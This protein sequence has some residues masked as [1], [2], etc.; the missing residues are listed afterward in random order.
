MRFIDKSCYLENERILVIGDLHLGYEQGLLEKGIS[1]PPTGFKE[2]MND[3]GKI[4]NNIGEIE[5]IVILGDLKHDFAGME[6]REA[7]NVLRVLE[8][9]KGK[10]KKI[11]VIKGNHDNYVIGALKKEGIE[12]VK[13]YEKGDILFMHGDKKVKIREGIKRIFLGHMHPAIS[14]KKNVKE[15]RYKCFLV[16]K[17]KNKEIIIL[18]S[19]F[20]LF[21][22]ADI[23]EDKGE[24]LAYDF[25]LNEFD[26]YIV[27]GK[28]LEVLHFGKLKDVGKLV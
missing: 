8:F 10:C 1:I 18:P 22:G 27:V 11:V 16:G 19:F 25:R 24:F 20:P 17:W 15:E 7:D 21:E 12:L 26:V 23:F 3:L 6:Y 2:T 28:D 5:E 13:Y 4:F 14:I 9:L